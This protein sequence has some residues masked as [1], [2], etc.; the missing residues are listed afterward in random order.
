MP[1]P[2]YS[3]GDKKRLIKPNKTNAEGKLRTPFRRDYARLIHCP[4]FRRLQG[5][6]QLFAGSEGDFFRNRLTHSLEVAQIGKSI[7]IALNGN[8][9]KFPEFKADNQRIDTDLVEFACLAHD[10][11]HP[12]FGHIGEE[13]LDDC[14]KE[15]GG[16]EGNAQ[17]F[18]VITRL[19]KKET[20]PGNGIQLPSSQAELTPGPQELIFEVVKDDKDLRGG[21]NATYRSMASGL[22]YPRAIPSN[23][24][25]R[26]E[27]GELGVSKGYYYFDDSLVNRIKRNV[28]GG[29]VASNP[30]VPFRTVEC[31]IM[32]VADDIAYST[33]DLEDTFKSGLLTPLGFWLLSSDKRITSKVADKIQRRINMFYPDKRR[34]FTESDLKQ[35]MFQFFSEWFQIPLALQQMIDAYE[36]AEEK[37]SMIAMHIGQKSRKIA[38]DGYYR[39]QFTSGLVDR[40]LRGLE[41]MTSAHHPALHEVRLELGTFTTVE[42]LKNL[43]FEVVISSSRLKVVEYRGR[44]IVQE[45]FHALDSKSGSKL[46]PDDQRSLYNAF[47]DPML[48]KRIICDFVAG[49]T[50]KYA[51][52]FYER[53]Y[54]TSPSSIYKPI[55]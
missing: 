34:Y 17:T 29:A 10:I 21:L 5:K 23:S 51:L 4:A 46:L 28:V 9:R 22:K 16:F 44:K 12:P 30:D 11:G 50:D 31:S 8:A 37:A 48:R 14:M 32:D 6:T 36:S 42:V 2:L 20:I 55:A 1:S 52:E 26:D 24:A 53:L 45:I 39:C 41:V 3:S 43:N 33:Y 7:A 15:Y 35:A 47:K 40:A 49:M 54:S 27:A 18:R 25:A 13:A 19:E 38:D